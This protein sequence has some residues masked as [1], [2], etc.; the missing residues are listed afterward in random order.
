M[1]SKEQQRKEAKR[2]LGRTI[3]QTTD[4][5]VDPGGPTTS[6]FQPSDLIQG[7]STSQFQSPDLIQEAT[8]TSDLTKSTTYLDDEDCSAPFIKKTRG[9][10]VGR[11]MNLRILELNMRQ[12]K[13]WDERMTKV[14]MEYM[15]RPWP[16][17]TPSRTRRRSASFPQKFTRCGDDCDCS[18]YAQCFQNAIAVQASSQYIAEFKH[19]IAAAAAFMRTSYHIKGGRPS[20]RCHLNNDLKCAS[21]SAGHRV[22]YYDSGQFGDF[23][24]HHCG[25]RL[26]RGE[27][28]K[29]KGGRQT[30]CCANGDVHTELMLSEFNELQ[31]PPNGFMEG[32]VGAK[33]ERL[34]EAFLNNTMPFNNTFAFASTHGEKAP[35]EQ[36]GGRMDTC[37]YNG[38]FSF[39]FSD[40]IA[41]GGRRPTFA[42]VYTLTPEAAL[43]IREE[44]F[45][46]AVAPH[47]KMEIIH[48]L[49]ELM[50]ENP[51][52]MAFQ[53]VGTKVQAATIATGNVPRFK[54]VLLTDRDLKS[55]ELKNRGDV[56]VIE[57]ADAP[58]AKQVAVIWIE[59]DGLPPQISGFWL[60]DKAGKMRELKNGMPQIDPCCFPLLH[61]CGTLGWRWFIN[62]RGRVGLREAHENLAI[63]DILDS[64]MGTVPQDDEGIGQQVGTLEQDHVP[65]E[66]P[67]PECVLDE[68]QT[69][70][71]S[72]SNENRVGTSAQETGDNQEGNPI[73]ETEVQMGERGRN[74]ISERQF[75]RYRMALRGD[76]KNSFHWLWFARRL[77]EYFTITVLNRIERNELDHLKEIQR[78]KNYRRILARE[79]ITA[80]EKGL[81]KWGR[82][83]KLGSI[84]L[85]PQT[86]AGSRQY[87]QGKYADLMTMVRHLGAPTWFVTFTGNPKW[88]EISEAL[89]GRENYVHR[90]D[91][92]CRIFM[93]KATEFI[94][95]V[96]ERCVLGKVAGWCYSVEHQKRGMPH[97]H[98][99]LI[100]EKGG[101]LTTPEQV[102]EYVCAQVRYT[103]YV[104]LAPGDDL[105]VG[106]RRGDKKQVM[107]DDH[108]PAADPERD[109]A[110][111]RYQRIPARGR[112]PERQ[113]AAC[114]QTHYKKRKGGR[115]AL[116]LDDSRVIPYNPYLLLK[117]GCHV[118]IEYVFGQ[119]ACKY[120]FKYL[121][122]G[123][124]KA[125]VQ[126]AQPRGGGSKRS[127]EDGEQ[128]FDYDEIAATF[129]VRY[130]TAMEA[131]LRL[132]SYKIV[133]TSHQIYTL[134]VHDEGGQTIVIEEGHEEEGRWKVKDN[135]RLT[136]FFKLCGDDSDASQLTYD[137]VPYYY[138]W[139][140]KA[141]SWKKRGRPLTEDPD[142]ARM[143][144]RVFTVSPRKHELFAMRM[145]L[146]HRPGPKNFKDLR[147]VDG[148]VFPTFAG[149]A[150]HLG[151]QVCDELFVRS[152]Q[153]ACSEMSNL[154]RLQHFFAM[155]IAH[156]HPSEPQK[157][158][159]Q[160]L[161]EMN[162]AAAGAY[163]GAMP[164]SIALRAA[165]VMRNI[166]Y[167]LNCMGTNSGDVGL[168][169]LPEDYDFQ[170]QANLLE[171]DN[172]LDDFYGG[173]ANQRRKSLQQIAVEQVGQ[174][175]AD[176]MVAFDKISQAVL[177]GGEQKLFFLEG[178]GGCGKTFFYNT[179]I[180]WCVAGKPMLSDSV[181][182]VWGRDKDTLRRSAVIAAASTGIAALLLIGGGT[183]H[184]HFYVP[185][186]V[187]DETA[188][189]L[190]FES[191]KAQQL[192]EAD[193]I[194]ID[195]I[196]MLSSKVLRYIDRLL[197]DVCA[198][199]FLL[200]ESLTI[201][202]RT[203]PGEHSLREW[204]K[205]IGS[206]QSKVGT[207]QLHIPPQLVLHNLE[208][209]IQ[210]CFPDALFL[211]P[212]SNAD[213][214]ANNAVL[215]PTNNDVQYINEIALAR[216]CGDAKDFP[217]ID[218]P[219]EP[220]DEF[221]NFRTD[222]NIEAVHNEMP[223]GMPPHKMVLKVG[224]PVMLIRNLDVTQGLCNGT[225]LQV[226]RMAEDNI[227]CRILTG[228]RAD[229]GHVIVLPRIQFEY[230]RG[231][232][233]RG[234]R[235]RRLQ[236]PVR[237]C[238]AMTI[239]KAQGQTLQRM[240]LVLNG[241]QCFSHG[242]VYVAMSRVTQMDG[243][244]VFAP[245]C[246][247]G[248]EEDTYIN[249]VVYHELLENTNVI[250]G[251]GDG[252]NLNE[253]ADNPMELMDMGMN[254]LG[255]GTGDADT[256]ENQIRANYDDSDDYFE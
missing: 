252:T 14:V 192:R 66:I 65:D 18:S 57:R 111:V 34:R 45:D 77:A 96:T 163:P 164:K 217:S 43:G 126:V 186:D 74:N 203:A 132:N 158:F 68:E 32:L 255:V 86:F 140:Y 156:A 11:R 196:S 211:D 50:R 127:G 31:Q 5:V 38:E 237:L 90:P 108:T 41:P 165:E 251:T 26:L 250:H 227:F 91:I 116:L 73:F 70:E 183:A 229:A 197:R 242:Q 85:M 52:G 106:S 7:P 200:V 20:V 63:Q 104:R 138:S 148:I 151:L 72:T 61:P 238:F 235:F 113:H 13:K 223:S 189:M 155:L 201:N 175:N 92:V 114:G 233:H 47:V 8:T 149:A 214:I 256:G 67:E 97:I 16:S 176:Q 109:W 254:E 48:K 12:H 93:D 178:A 188:P 205:E 36:M 23:I 89:R 131:F 154:K 181:N 146:L 80:M 179:L 15:Q 37:K 210:F 141:R 170:R 22:D 129:K 59:E 128:M 246:Q 244:R 168:S 215:C 78:K 28:E 190:N 194:I 209:A 162:P 35:A 143:F 64:T 222:F 119:K 130:M 177:S 225:R 171:E 231:R 83:A 110:E 75:Y 42:Q 40:L 49:E 150:Q 228:P 224:T 253:V 69:Q 115:S 216:M 221:H 133:G 147:T 56:T 1:P 137:R 195:E 33:D 95:D 134:S 236:F 4:S 198:G 245:Y 124:E 117:Y 58:S 180:K 105:E 99:L 159:D 243:I 39:M 19:G 103:N 6:Q 213:A 184:R 118:N 173:D 167:F 27:Y 53:T 185:N 54:I 240:A 174:L 84:F 139:N 142:K 3:R 17:N 121:L 120:I 21:K 219:L 157:L 30:P 208:E 112:V 88:P 232:H 81:Q 55:D 98:L 25:A 82:N 220:N 241:R 207:N 87:Y 136:A 206:G 247:S 79:Y 153:E 160:F 123:F 226:M 166:E 24:C 199:R 218:E 29:I 51:F 249:N 62:K 10:G 107:G 94:K 187:N 230:G 71:Q 234:L 102:D 101:R 122:K 172:M 125:Y 202:M 212:L 239:N 135:T 9:D 248:D 193:L 182:T 44:N 145:L 204:L 76:A 100:L 191:Q 60:A 2:L 144:V 46:T 152:M 169:G 161:D